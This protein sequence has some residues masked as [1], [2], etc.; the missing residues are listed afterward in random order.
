MPQSTSGSDSNTDKKKAGGFFRWL[1]LCAV[2]A[3]LISVALTSYL[4][5]MREQ[6]SS[7]V[8]RCVEVCKP[9]SIK[10][11]D[12]SRSVCECQKPKEK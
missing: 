8:Y 10:A 4:R 9:L 7:G 12:G 5:D 1:F 2:T 3:S 6:A 11:Y